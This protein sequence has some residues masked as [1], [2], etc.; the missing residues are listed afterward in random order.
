MRPWGII[1]GLPMPWSWG[2]GGIIMPW[3]IMPGPTLGEG[4]CWG[5]PWERGCEPMGVI[6]RGLRAGMEPEEPGPII[7]GGPWWWF[8]PI[9]T[10]GHREREGH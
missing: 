3:G 2:L 6:P 10:E 4:I 1:W 7:R 5:M 9:P 8:I